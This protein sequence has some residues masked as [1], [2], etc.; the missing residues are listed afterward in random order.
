MGTNVTMYMNDIV[1]NALKYIRVVT[2][3][4]P[5]APFDETLGV[6]VLNEI[7]T[8]M[9]ATTA[10]I[11]YF[12]DYT[13]NVVASQKKY[14]IGQGSLADVSRPYFT[15]VSF[16]NILYVQLSYPVDIITDQEA[17]STITNTQITFLPPQARVYWE[18]GSDGVTYTVIDF[19]YAP[20]QTYQCK[21]RG[22]PTIGQEVPTG[23]IVELP[24]YYYA[25]LKMET[26][27]RLIPY[28]GRED[29]WTDHE[30]RMYQEA[31]QKVRASIELDLEVAVSDALMPR[32]R[33]VY[34]SRLGVRI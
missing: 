11:P 10:E 8:E 7:L 24:V 28:Y 33:L 19:L 18:N 17:L 14:Y 12:Y 1:Q 3:F 26:A 22:K 25:W 23:A 30:E 13:F 21:V 5:I 15:D 4:A 16:I 20:D 27:R 9:S 2:E 6:K 31:L 29:A 34:G 32:D